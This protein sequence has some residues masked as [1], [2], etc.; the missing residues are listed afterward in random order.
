NVEP[1]NLRV[2]CEF[3]S[4]LEIIIASKAKRDRG[5]RRRVERKMAGHS[6]AQVSR[7]RINET[8]KLCVNYRLFE[9]ARIFFKRLEYAN[10]KPSATVMLVYS[11]PARN[12]NL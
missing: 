5:Q 12:Q 7:V 4:A 3:Y 11:R 6:Y 8:R 2:V 10:R 9:L 1:R